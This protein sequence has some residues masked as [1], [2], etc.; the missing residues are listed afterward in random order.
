MSNS[1]RFLEIDLSGAT[2]IFV[3]GEHIVFPDKK[4]RAILAMLALAPRHQATRNWIKARLWSNRNEQMASASLRQALTVIRK[5]LGR[6][7]S[8]LITSNEFVSLDTTKLK[9]NY[10]APGGE[11]L[12]GMDIKDQGF[13]EW[14]REE[15]SAFEVKANGNLYTQ[16][17]SETTVVE[18]SLFRIGLLPTISISKSRR[19][20]ETGNYL[21]DK[22]AMGFQQN[23]IANIFDYRQTFAGFSQTVHDSTIK[24]ADLFVQNAVTEY[25][26]KILINCRFYDAL[27]NKQLWSSTCEIQANADTYECLELKIFTNQVLDFTEYL[28]NSPGFTKG[29]PKRAASSLALAAIGEILKARD[30]D[31]AA[32]DKN[33]IQ[34]FDLEPNSVYLAWRTQIFAYLIGERLIQNDT[35]YRNQ[36]R[37]I[38]VKTTELGRFN[39]VSLSLAAH[40]HSFVF[41]EYD[42][43]QDLYEMVLKQNPTQAICYDMAATTNVYT[44]NKVVAY[45]QAKRALA[46]GQY[47]PFK[48][49]IDTTCSMAAAINKKFDEAAFYSDR[50]NRQKPTYTA[51]LRMRVASKSLAG[52]ANGAKSSFKQLK[53]L[54]PDFSIKLLKSDKYPFHGTEENK[55]MII[56]G[57]KPLS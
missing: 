34:A 33:L 54:E 15:R 49:C 11:L 45:Q 44:G 41:K 38:V 35:E 43:A 39:P 55:R 47:S 25:D 8:I 13:E 30:G 52:D 21:L 36:L 40:A 5:R 7:S 4:A 23:G 14:L 20:L 50:V 24:K 16:Y 3:A 56:E 27:E 53:A 10:P 28:F 26:D 37:E 18:P 6:L 31:L 19:A 9:I 46:L 17:L 32:A 48:Y 29:N 2:S 51:A 1:V 42:K 57:F 12:A 22:L